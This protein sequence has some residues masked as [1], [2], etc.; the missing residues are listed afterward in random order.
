[1]VLETKR[2]KIPGRFIVKDTESLKIGIHNIVDM[3]EKVHNKAV[4]TCVGIATENKAIFRKFTS[5]NKTQYANLRPTCC[6][7]Y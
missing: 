7:G 5:V 2:Y 4:N 6:T 1:V 3:A